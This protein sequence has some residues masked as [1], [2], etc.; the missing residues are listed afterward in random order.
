MISLKTKNLMK[1]VWQKQPLQV[2]IDKLKVD[3]L[4]EA[5]LHSIWQEFACAEPTMATC[6]TFHQN[7]TT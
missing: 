5:S 6:N 4:V 1:N 3:H 2:C 7:S